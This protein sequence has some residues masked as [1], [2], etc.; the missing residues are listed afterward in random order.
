MHELWRGNA[1][2]WECDELGHLNVRHYLAKAMQAAGTLSDMIGMRRAFGS[3]ALATLIVRDLHVRFL[4]E[5][6]PG[7]PL[8][9]E[10]GVTQATP[11]GLSIVLMMRHA[12]QDRLAASFTMTLDHADPRTGRPF[13]WPARV[14]SAMEGLTVALP[15]EA[16]PRG[17]QMSEPANAISLARA[18]AL[19]LQPVGRGRVLPED[20][21]IFGR[22]RPECAIGKI[23]DSVIHFQA[24]FPEQWDNH[25]SG[26]K[27]R[28]ASALLELR[29]VYRNYP[30][31]GDGFVVRSGLTQAGEKV[32]NLVHWV[33]DPVTG[34]PWWSAEGVGC[35][36]DLEARKLVPASGETLE[37]LKDAVIHGLAI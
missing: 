33:L 5:A 21:D 26:E 16:G 11:A 6:R 18:D 2:A 15:G 10:G 28:R 7:A 14:S 24:G 3:G 37:R 30:Q 8:M 27:L 9:I 1:N 19:G 4:A 17:L 35:M 25:A 13:A 34:E 29:I 12:A 36:M 23:S 20:G 31:P 22:M 32:R